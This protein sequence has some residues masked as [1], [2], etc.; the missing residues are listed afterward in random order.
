MRDRQIKN[1]KINK[2]WNTGTTKDQGN[3][4]DVQSPKKRLNFRNFNHEPQW[5][6]GPHH[7]ELSV[8]VCPERRRFRVYSSRT[9]AVSP[10]RGIENGK[11]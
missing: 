3:V 4:M 1:E 6:F 8:R 10:L 5:A 11:L 9:G 7:H 2:T